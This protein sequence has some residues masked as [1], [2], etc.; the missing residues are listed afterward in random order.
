[1]AMFLIVFSRFFR[2]K[3]DS[4]M[5]RFYWYRW[6]QW[7]HV[8]RWLNVC[9]SIILQGLMLREPFWFYYNDLIY[10]HLPK[11]GLEGLIKVD[12]KFYRESL[13]YDLLL[14]C[15]FP[16]V[17]NTA[18]LLRLSNIWNQNVFEKLK[19]HTKPALNSF[20]KWFQW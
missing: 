17:F 16:A 10:T 3:S 4:F 14:P 6:A 19:L 5:K 9:F 20:N 18:F 13:H 8:Y 15:N 11:L 7:Q 1:M 12:I 2:S